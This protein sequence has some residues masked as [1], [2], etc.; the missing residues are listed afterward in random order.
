VWIFAS[1]PQY[2]YEGLDSG[3]CVACRLQA[4]VP[5]ELCSRTLLG[6]TLLGDE[7]AER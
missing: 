2:S 3:W 4:G 5:Q 7:G 6:H 1:G